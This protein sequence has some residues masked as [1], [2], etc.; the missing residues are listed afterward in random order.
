[1][2]AWRRSSSHFGTAQ[3]PAGPFLTDLGGELVEASNMAP[4]VLTHFILVEQGGAPGGPFS[5]FTELPI[6]SNPLNID[7]AGFAGVW[8]RAAVT[9]GDGIPITQWSNVVQVTA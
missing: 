4:Y 6:D 8:A 9:L 3:L 2:K 5:T 7:F 1:M